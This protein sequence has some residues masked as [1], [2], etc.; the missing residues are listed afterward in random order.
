MKQVRINQMDVS[1]SFE[2]AN[3]FVYGADPT[4]AAAH[5]HFDQV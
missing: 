3:V 5:S 4:L 1:R 2:A